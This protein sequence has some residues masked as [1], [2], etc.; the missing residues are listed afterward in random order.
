MKLLLDFCG[1][2]SSGKSTLM[3]D[4]VGWFSQRSQTCYVVPSFSSGRKG[5]KEQDLQLYGKVDDKSQAS[6]SII[7][8]GN[9][10]KALVDYDVVLT[11]DW[12]VRGW[13]YAHASPHCTSFV[14]DA[15]LNCLKFFTQL[16]YYTNVITLFF[17]LPIEFEM[18]INGVRPVD[19][20][21]RQRVQQRILLCYE[22]CNI[23][24]VNVG[25]SVYQ[26]TNIVI[27][28]II[29]LYERLSKYE[30]DVTP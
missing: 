23:T 20:E 21:Y 3:T 30:N 15:L 10:L 4:V 19:E 27:D 1:V 12:F 5:V 11:T 18:E 8:L 13:A 25:G 6:I 22:K 24:P 9:I 29:D 28:N 26:R 17:Y 14:L 16:D 7:N 2:H